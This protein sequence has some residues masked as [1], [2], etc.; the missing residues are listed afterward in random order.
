MRIYIPPVL[1]NLLTSVLLVA[2]LGAAAYIGFRAFQTF[3]SD[4][5]LDQI[6]SV[7]QKAHPKSK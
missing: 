5:A 1:S 4:S 7:L 3:S 2:S 6:P